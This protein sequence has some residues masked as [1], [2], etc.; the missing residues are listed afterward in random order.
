MTF[1][2]TQVLQTVNWIFDYPF[3][4]IIELSQE[5]RIWSYPHE[6]NSELLLIILKKSQNNSKPKK[7]HVFIY[8]K[9]INVKSLTISHFGVN[10]YI[11]YYF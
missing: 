4:V 10:W 2:F 3:H 11:K 9:V 6:L 8:K 1:Q 7:V 5:I